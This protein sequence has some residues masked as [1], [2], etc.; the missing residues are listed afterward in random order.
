MQVN[1]LEHGCC[2][3]IRHVVPN[4]ARKPRVCTILQVQS[5]QTGIQAQGLGLRFSHGLLKLDLQ[6]QPIKLDL[7][8][9]MARQDL[10][11][12]IFILA[13]L[14]IVPQTGTR[15]KNKRAH[16]TQCLQDSW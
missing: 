4:P 12:S 3:L 16:L 9:G 8:L 7:D 10:F 2:S 14:P 6:S 13:S 15:N 5:L 1:Q 11:C